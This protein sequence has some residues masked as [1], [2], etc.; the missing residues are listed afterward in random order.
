MLDTKKTTELKSVLHSIVGFAREV[1][2]ADTATLYIY[3]P[4]IDT[5]NMAT[6]MGGTKPLEAVDRKPRPSGT[7]A[8]IVKTKKPL[9]SNN[10]QEH[11]LFKASPYTQKEGICSVAGIPLIRDDTVIGVLYFNYRSTDQ[12]TEDRKRIFEPFAQVAA[13]AIEST[14]L[15]EERSRMAEALAALHRAGE[16][17]LSTRDFFLALENREIQSLGIDAASVYVVLE[18]IV[19]TAVKVL[20]ADIVTIYQ[21]DQAI[22]DFQLPPVIAGDLREAG[23]PRRTKIYPDDAA[24][25]V[26]QQSID[27]YFARDSQNDQIMCGQLQYDHEG[28]PKE[29]FVGREGIVSSCILRLRAEEEI[30]GVM[31]VN[32]RTPQAFSDEQKAVVSVFADQAARAIQNARLYKSIFDT[33]ATEQKKRLEAERKARFDNLAGT[34]FHRVVNEVGTIRA[35][36]AEL[37]QLIPATTAGYDDIALELN[38]IDRD[39]DRFITFARKIRQRQPLEPSR[40]DVNE[41]VAHILSD[42]RVPSNIRLSSNLVNLPLTISIDI[43]L[44]ITFV[45]N[46]LDNAADAMPDGGVLT[47]TTREIVDGT[48]KFAEIEIQDTGVGIPEDVMNTLFEPLSTTKPGGTGVG[49]YHSKA[50]VEDVGGSIQV[51]TAV[52]KGS[53][54]TVRLPLVE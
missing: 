3:D 26:M 2:Q 25:L 44:F 53:T 35:A 29:R 8:T 18:K 34:F 28:R 41:Q 9:F 4:S 21:Y 33:L 43:S 13:I 37:R 6:D 48:S 42:V 24:A 32:F 16:S 40:V 27:A 52:G 17:I 39:V 54:F 15:L 46:L 49:L 23:I 30:V 22:N 38:S 5:F 10:A 47:V 12:I 20:N 45:R 11:P 51:R 7:T 31:F 50:I 36:T 19:K 14:R 1:V